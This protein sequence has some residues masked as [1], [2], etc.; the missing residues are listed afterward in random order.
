MKKF[1]VMI[2]SV[3]MFFFALGGI[4]RPFL[5]RFKSEK[6]TVSFTRQ[7]SGETGEDA[8]VREVK[9]LNFVSND[10]QNVLIRIPEPNIKV[11]QQL[12]LKEKQVFEF[13]RQPNPEAPPPPEGLPRVPGKNVVIIKRMN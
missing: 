6:H 11:E 12:P 10:G 5:D 3:A 8:E 9:T 13:E 2:F 4:A 1:A 7:A